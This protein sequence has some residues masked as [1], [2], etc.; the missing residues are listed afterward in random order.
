[1]TL[2]DLDGDRD[3]DTFADDDRERL[4]RQARR[5]YRVMLDNR[6]HTLGEIGELTGDPEQS[7]SARLRDLRKARFGA[8]EIERRR[9]V[10]IPGLWEYRMTGRRVQPRTRD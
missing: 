2:F 4:N 9:V 3:G 1:M 8:H 10:G 5:V 6:W 7:V